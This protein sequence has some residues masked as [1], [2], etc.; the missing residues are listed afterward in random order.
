MISIDRVRCE[1]VGLGRSESWGGQ[2]QSQTGFS[3]W[4]GVLA[5]GWGGGGRTG[6]E[7]V[8]DT[9]DAGWDLQA[10]DCD[11]R[12]RDGSLLGPGCH[13]ILG[14]AQREFLCT[15]EVSKRVCS[16]FTTIRRYSD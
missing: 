15:S 1:L 4:K 11:H 2:S 8:P 9:S 5:L 14:E 10:D 6:I 7:S 16:S 13:G 3:A 12:G